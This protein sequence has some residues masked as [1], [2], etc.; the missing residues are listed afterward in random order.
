M[1]ESIFQNKRLNKDK[2]V[3]FGFVLENEQYIFSTNI[4]DNQFKFDVIIGRG[5][6]VKTRLTDND[7]NEEYTLYLSAGVSGVFIGKIRMEIENILQQVAESCFETSVFKNELTRQVIQYVKDKYGDDLEFLWEKLPKAAIWRRKDNQKW[8]ATLL[9][10]AKNKLG[11]EGTEAV[12]VIGLRAQPQEI[13]TLV[14]HKRYF[15]GYHMNKKHWLTMCL[16][17]SLPLVEICERI[18]ESYRLAKKK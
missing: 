1:F 13:E 7:M 18:D 17:D 12:E 4:L 8:Y 5:E 9:I 2:L 6:E 14:D 15:R 3:D 11:L 10:I 16:D